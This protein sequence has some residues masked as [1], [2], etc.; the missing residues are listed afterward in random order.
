MTRECARESVSRREFLAAT[1]AGAV[2]AGATATDPPAPARLPQKRLGN[3]GVTVPAIGLGT[4]P[5]GHLPRKEAVALYH[6]CLDAGV[7]Y[8]DTAPALGGYGDAQTFLAPVLKERRQEAFVVTKCFEPDGEKALALLKSNLNELG[9]ERADLVYAHSIGADE[10]PPETVFGKTGVCAALTKAKRDGL[11][12]F[13]GVSGH[14]RTARF[15]RALDEWE[16]DVQMNAV[17]LVARHTYDFEGKVWPAAA[18]KNVGLAAMKVYGGA[19]GGRDWSARLPERLR[20]AAFRYALGLPGVAVV[21]LGMKTEDELRQNLEWL[22]A[23]KPL[24]GDELAALEG[25]TRALA[26]KWGSVYGAVS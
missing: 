19:A 5:A 7:T 12:R 25:P 9:V 22:K 15:L 6:A 4:A 11:T 3:T 20:S 1:A 23:F 24:T 16:Y 18:K 13:V 8:L 2:A 26:M 21:V 14:N 10:M 17:G